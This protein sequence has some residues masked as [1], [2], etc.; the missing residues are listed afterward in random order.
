MAYP[1]GTPGSGVTNVTTGTAFTSLAN[2][3]VVRDNYT[4]VDKFSLVRSL[5]FQLALVQNFVNRTYI[6]RLDVPVISGYFSNIQLG[7]DTGFDDYNLIHASGWRVISPGDN[8]TRAT[9]SYLGAYTTTSRTRIWGEY[10]KVSGYGTTELTTL[11]RSSLTIDNP[12]TQYWANMTAS[13]LSFTCPGLNQSNVDWDRIRQVSYA[14]ENTNIG[15]SFL[16]SGIAV[17][18]Y[19]TLLTYSSL[20]M[21]NFNTG[22]EAWYR[23]GSIYLNQVAAVVNNI[24]SAG[25]TIYG[26]QGENVIQQDNISIS[27]Y[28]I[29]YYMTVNYYSIAFWDHDFLYARFGRNQLRFINPTNSLSTFSSDTLYMQGGGSPGDINIY[30]EDLPTSN[31]G[32]GYLYIN[33][34]NSNAITMGT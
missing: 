24:T 2:L 17:T 8:M 14:G 32:A 12:T 18:D 13:G 15:G 16:L 26:D 19:Y 1:Y 34:A 33:A 27:G 23:P 31:P 4:S 20:Y 3:R 22:A 25:M 30:L 29:D 9:S 5:G 10:V 21:T 7:V 6:G 28:G 11:S